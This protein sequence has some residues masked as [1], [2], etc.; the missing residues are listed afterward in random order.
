M[1]LVFP[2]M[3]KFLAN[4]ILVVSAFVALLALKIP[5]HAVSH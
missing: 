1:S 5:A 4:I 2:P 3:P